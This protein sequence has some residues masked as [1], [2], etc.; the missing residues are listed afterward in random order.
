MNDHSFFFNPG[1]EDNMLIR[2]VRTKILLGALAIVLFIMILSTLT[3]SFIIYD[4]NRT[5]SFQLLVQSLNIIR[6]DVIAIGERLAAQTSQA[7]SSNDIGINLDWAATTSYED[8]VLMGMESTL[9]S[10]MTGTY[11]ISQAADIWKTLIYAKNGELAGF[12]IIDDA[13]VEIGFPRTDDFLVNRWQNGRQLEENSWQVVPNVESVHAIYPGTIPKEKTQGFGLTDG[14]LCLI[15]QIPVTASVIDGT[16]GEVKE[17]QVGFIEA[18][19]KLDQAFIDRL[20]RITGNRIGI[21]HEDSVISGELS[22]YRRSGSVPA[23]TVGHGWHIRT[24][25]PTLNTT[26]LGDTAYFQGEW[27]V[28]TNAGGYLASIVALYS[29]E[30]AMSNTWAIITILILVA[31]GCIVIVSPLSLWFSNSLSRPLEALARTL[32]KVDRDGDFQQRMAIRSE[33]EI[34]RASLAFN[35]LMSTLQDAIRNVNEVLLMISKGNLSQ[36]ITGSYQGE[37]LELKTHTNN[38]VEVL[39]RAIAQVIEASESVYN[40]SVELSS[41]SQTLASGTTQQA[42]TL[43]EISSSMSEVEQRTKNNSENADRAQQLTNE[44]IKVV[45][46]G[47]TQME[48]MLAS[49]NRIS[50]TSAEVSKI[51]KVIDEIAFQ[52]NL[53]ALN[54]AI[55]AARAGKYGK[56]FAVVA[57]EVRSLAA[58]SAEAARTTTDLIQT[59]LDEVG[60]GV[61][62][63]NNTASIL[64]DIM[65]GINRS[66]DL[67]N[68]IAADSR[69]QA[70]SVEEINA[71]LTNVNSVVQQNSAISVQSATSSEEM[72]AQATRLKEL[73]AEF[74]LAEHDLSKAVTTAS[75]SASL[76]DDF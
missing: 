4:Q 33:D 6:D 66:N 21:V 63:A 5:A 20:E 70:A 54:A 40:A 24:Q 9:Q 25:E 58:R 15:S 8:G 39:S 49:M 27:P 16:T 23:S 46:S 65:A 32:E 18:V 53:L 51:V 17:D 62:N 7:A 69:E 50:N 14:Y 68:E 12:V 26:Q 45:E 31:L 67:V 28:Y 10:L 55:E 74:R 64:K 35:T 29:M 52:T 75:R 13:T 42:A 72:A 19:Y 1:E 76:D 47:N 36:Q 11:N 38:S 41:S 2:R 43:E 48:G 37:L 60:N 71:G 44:S 73:M 56:G 59:S 34:G 3:L 61:D 57:E 30:M 22:G